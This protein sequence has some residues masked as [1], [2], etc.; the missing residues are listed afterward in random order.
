MKEYKRPLKRSIFIGCSTF[1][2]LMCLILS[3]LTYK[4]YNRSLYR[5]YEKRMT[6][7]INYVESHI[8]VDDLYECVQTGVESEKY[9]ELM[10]FMDDM[11][12]TYDIHFLYLVQPVSVSPPV[13]MNILSADTA[14]GRANDPDGYY[15]GYL[16]YDDYDSTE[17][18]R[19]YD[20]Y[21]K[22]GI[23]FYKD[24]SS[25]GYDYTAARTLFN[26]RGEA[27]AMLC[28]DIEVE[29][30]ESE[31]RAFTITNVVLIVVLGLAFISL[32]LLWMTRNI[33]DPISKLEKSVVSFAQISHEQKDPEKLDYTAPDIHTDNEVEALSNAVE[34]MSR[35]MKD[36]VMNILQ[37]EDEV[38]D[39][40]TKVDHMDTVAYQD[41]LTH[42]KN[43]AW[44]DKIRERI[45]QEIIT[46]RARFGL[47][48]I[49]LNNLKK[50]NDTYGHEHGNDYI[51]GSCHIICVIF[52]HSPVF[53][54]G[55]DE[56]VVLLENG[57]YDHRHVLMQRLKE[58]FE[59][60]ST[61]MSKEPWER[62]AAAFGMTIFDD[63]QDISMDDVF[64]RAD[65][66]MYQH[67]LETKSARTD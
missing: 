12:E 40:K 15:L 42:V 18:Q 8:D 62:Y 21:K 39:M 31:I 1:I 4:T 5:A 46:G 49:D 48:M 57:D 16:D 41:A 50:I 64:K 67:K 17:I 2:I 33:T 65:T 19:Y 29:N 27:F 52:Q 30:L 10:A 47:V 28:V 7:I 44:Y 25:W 23:V 36:Y 13:M 43:K 59:A 45:D 6:D 3:V 11:M 54:I 53:R 55:G 58:E 56:F 66:L 63:S 35:D 61:D 26:S 51:S 38:Q 32:F 20:A 37:V 14:E 24:F 60:T 22:E 9:T 34:Q